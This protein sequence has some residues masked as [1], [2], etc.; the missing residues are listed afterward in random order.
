MATISGSQGHGIHGHGDHG[1]HDVSY[2]HPKGGVVATIW[3]WMTTIDHKKIG[4]MYLFAI[5][6][7]FFL[8]GVAA[9]MVRVELFTPTKQIVDAAGTHITGQFFNVG[10]GMNKGNETYNRIMTLH[11]VVMVFLVIVPSVPAS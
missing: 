11:G 10:E 2:L 3:D 9:L 1:G 6:F 7:M 8:G 5:L 4:V